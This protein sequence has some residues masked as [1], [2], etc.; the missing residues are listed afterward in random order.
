MSHILFGNL[1]ADECRP[2]CFYCGQELRPAC[3]DEDY[4]AILDVHYMICEMAYSHQAET[5]TF[6]AKSP[7]VFSAAESQYPTGIVVVT[8]EGYIAI[9]S[10]RATYSSWD[11][12]VEAS[13]KFVLYAEARGSL[14]AGL[15]TY[16]PAI[17]TPY[18]YNKPATPDALFETFASKLAKALS[19]EPV[20][21]ER[22]LR[23]VVPHP[24]MR[25]PLAKAQIEYAFSTFI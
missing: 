13:R 6:A 16:R 10:K 5:W 25:L 17:V 14:R 20:L 7:A 4:F 2:V 8:P 9:E 22:M 12:L 3:Y 11:E 19:L 21:A 1:S 18:Q 24:S 23:S 15:L